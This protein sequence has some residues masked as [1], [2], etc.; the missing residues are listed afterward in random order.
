MA[1]LIGT[2][3]VPHACY[4]AFPTIHNLLLMLHSPAVRW[5]CWWV[6]LQI[7]NS[8]SV[9]LCA[10]S[11]CCYH[12]RRRCTRCF[13]HAVYFTPFRPR[14]SLFAV[15]VQKPCIGLIMWYP[16]GASQFVKVAFAQ[17]R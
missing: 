8:L 3:T 13:I 11:L 12:I 1:V 4:K 17:P 14:F 5:L 9:S 16:L 15:K 7:Y 6:A 2:Q 10:P